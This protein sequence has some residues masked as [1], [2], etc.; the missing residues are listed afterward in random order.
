MTASHRDA[1]AGYKDDSPNYRMTLQATEQ[2]CQLQMTL[3]AA[4]TILPATWMT[5][6]CRNDAVS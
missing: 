5:A 2:H 6:N 4:E 1:F 3:P